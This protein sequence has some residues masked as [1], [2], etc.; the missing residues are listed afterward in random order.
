MK[1]T[2][3][4]KPVF[5]LASFVLAS[6][7]VINAA[8]ADGTEE[9]GP[10]SIPIA[11]GSGVL[12]AGTG[13]NTNQPGDISIEIPAGVTVNQVL[14]YWG[15]RTDAG[16]PLSGA[17]D[18]IQVNGSD[19]TGPLIGGP[20]PI[21]NDIPS[22]T[23]RAD[24]TASNWVTAGATNVVTVDGLDFDYQDDGAAVV[25]IW[26]DGSEADIRI[27]DGNDFAFLPFG[28]QTVPVEFPVEPS[29]EERMAYVW[30]IVSDITA[31]RPNAVDVTI[32][33]D[34]TSLTNLLTSALG[35]LL[36]VVQLEV[37]V[38][39]GAS[40][41]MVQVLSI[42][43]GSGEVPASLAWMFVAWELLEPVDE[44]CTYTIG[45]WKTHPEDWPTNSLS[46]F[47]E[48][49]AMDLL[50]SPP[51]KGNA[52]IILAHQ[53]IGAELNVVNGASIPQEVE[54]AWLD[55][56]ALLVQYESEAYIPKKTEDRDLAIYLAGMLDDYNNGLIGPGHCD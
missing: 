24:I 30:L 18:T 52:Y 36:D 17:D 37:P 45:Y 21:V 27:L 6:L 38:P 49:E 9:L 20:T 11:E 26:D 10:P 44:G 43:D 16:S 47:T 22:Y 5:G 23:Y 31:P 55:A 8:Y 34:T 33:G 2:S 14:L 15:G 53:Y 13:L 3:N 19:V 56:Q 50:W 42:D 39:A 46:I 7:I 41:V 1:G 25:V 54:Q 4:F 32:D 29:A 51:K 12:V 28:M 48:E 35:D 40:N